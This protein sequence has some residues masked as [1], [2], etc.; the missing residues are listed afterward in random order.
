MK[1]YIT[2]EETV[3][4]GFEIKASSSEEAL[5]IA[6]EKYNTGEIVL[7]PG[8]LISKKMNIESVDSINT[9]EWVEF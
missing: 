4:Q 2:I 5:K 7:E 9:D 3:S 1:Y 6:K 8:N